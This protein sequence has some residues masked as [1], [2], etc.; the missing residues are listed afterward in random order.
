MTGAD[1]ERGERPPDTGTHV[2]AEAVDAVRPGGALAPKPR[3]VGVIVESVIPLP[4]A[5]LLASAMLVGAAVGRSSGIADAAG[6]APR[7]GP[8]W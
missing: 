7:S 1:Y 6:E 2:V 4:R 5:S 3:A 8:T